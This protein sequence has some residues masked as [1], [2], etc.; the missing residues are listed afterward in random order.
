[1]AKGVLTREEV[2]ALV[3]AVDAE[4]GTVDGRH[5]GPVM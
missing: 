3:E 4:D 2:R 5:G 1:V